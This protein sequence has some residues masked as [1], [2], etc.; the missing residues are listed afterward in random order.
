M[1][2]Y[3]GAEMLSYIQAGMILYIEAEMLS[4]I[5]ASMTLYIQAEM[6]L[7]YTGFNDFVYK[8]KVHKKKVKKKLTSVSFM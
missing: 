7:I 5:Q 3:I 8:G 6:L 2:L 4:Y 1:T